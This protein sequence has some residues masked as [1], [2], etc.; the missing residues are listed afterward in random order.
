MTV[1]FSQLNT[2]YHGKYFHLR[3]TLFTSLA[4]SHMSVEQL[5]LDRFGEWNSF[6]RAAKLDRT[7]ILPKRKEEQLYMKLFHLD[8][9]YKT[10]SSE[11]KNFRKIRSRTVKLVRVVDTVRLN[12]V[13]YGFDKVITPCH[14]LRVLINRF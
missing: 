2:G 1:P 12:T 13:L 5:Y 10:E 3:L 6:I 11:P 4:P 9:P 14:F 8:L 7:V